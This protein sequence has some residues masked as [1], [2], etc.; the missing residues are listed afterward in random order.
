VAGV[1]KKIRKFPDHLLRL[2]PTEG[3]GMMPRQWR[4]PMISVSIII[5][6]DVVVTLG[7]T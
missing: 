7:E 1:S 6:G 2:L 5:F 3:K 4:L